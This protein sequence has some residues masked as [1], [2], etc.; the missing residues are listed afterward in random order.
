LRIKEPRLILRERDDDDDDDEPSFMCDLPFNCKPT[1]HSL[2]RAG[3]SG[4]RIPTELR[5]FSP[6]QNVQTGSGAHPSGTGVSF[7]E[8]KRP[9]RGIGHPTPS[10]AKIKERVEL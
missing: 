1:Y 7:L 3:R 9:G 10:R 6:L 4:V 5:D 8:V 2:N